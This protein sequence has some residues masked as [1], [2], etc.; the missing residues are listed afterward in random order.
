MDVPEREGRLTVQQD[1]IE[2]WI[3]DPGMIPGFSF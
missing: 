1:K 3:S 2:V